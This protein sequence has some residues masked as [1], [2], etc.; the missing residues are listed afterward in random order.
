[1]HRNF[2]LHYNTPLEASS[3]TYQV[4]FCISVE[5]DVAPIPYGVTD[6]VIPASRCAKAQHLGTRE[7]ILAAQYLLNEWLPQSGETMSEYPLIFHY[8]NVGP[9]VLERDMI[10]DVY[11][12]LR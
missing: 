6:N 4:D 1:M 8:V 3:A 5:R 9:D 12:P 10:T 7:N 2:G 11:L